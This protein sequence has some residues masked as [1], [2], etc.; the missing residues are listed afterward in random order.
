MVRKI[1]SP[2]P[3][4]E[5]EGEGNSLFVGDRKLMNHFMV[6]K[7]TCGDRINYDHQEI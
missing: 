6:L 7:I 2:I 4:G 3:M 1:P 5:G